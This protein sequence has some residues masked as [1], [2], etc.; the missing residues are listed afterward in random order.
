MVQGAIMNFERVQGMSTDGVAGPAVWESLIK[1][2]L[3]NQMN[4]DGYTYAYVSENL[5]ETLTLWH[6]GVVVLKTLANTGIPQTP[7]YLGTFPVYVRYRTQT[8]KGINPFGAHYYDPG[9]PYVNYFKG[10]DA[11]HGFPRAAYG[12]PQSLGCVEL[13]I[14]NAAKVWPYMHYGTLVTVTPPTTS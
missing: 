8:M 5:P 13:P 3:A 6:N 4:P 11:V 14:P 12:F 1:A 9:I 10:G 2:D 7:T